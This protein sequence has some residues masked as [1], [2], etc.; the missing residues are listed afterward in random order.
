MLEEKRDE[1]CRRGHCLRGKGE[2]ENSKSDHEEELKN[3][4]HQT[5][6][7]LEETVILNVK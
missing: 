1:K 2:E 7:T 6:K 5:D 3:S 4:R